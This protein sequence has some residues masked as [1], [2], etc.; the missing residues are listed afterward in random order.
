[1]NRHFYRGIAPLTLKARNAG[2][3]FFVE[4]I[5][6]PAKKEVLSLFLR[7]GDQLKVNLPLGTYELKYAAGETWYGPG[8]L[9]GNATTFSRPYSLTGRGSSSSR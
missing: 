5:G 9:F 8:W 7:S 6:L 2:Q 3:H 1:M 4:L